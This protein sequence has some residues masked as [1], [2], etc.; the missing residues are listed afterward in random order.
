MRRMLRNV[1]IVLSGIVGIVLIGILLLIPTSVRRGFPQHQGQ[2][3]IEGLDGPA[4]IYRDSFGIPH[5]YATTEHDVIF[6]QGYVH[7]QDRFWQ[8]D[9]QRH[10]SS[11]RL[12]ELIGTNG[13]ETDIFLRTLGWERVAREELASLPEEDV[14]L[15][16]AY[17]DGVNA[18]IKTH[19]GTVMGLEYLFL[20]LLNAAY[21]PEPWTPLHSL[22]W[23]KAMAW[24]LRG[25]MDTEIER[26]ILLNSLADLQLDVNNLYPAYPR[27]MPVI[28]PNFELAG[29]SIQPGAS[30]V[31]PPPSHLNQALLEVSRRFA[32]ADAVLG[33]AADESTGSNSWVVSGELTATGMPLLANDPHL[34]AT[35]PPIWYQNGLHCTPKGPRCAIDAV[36]FSFVGN[37]LIVTGHNDRIS[38]GFTNVGPDVMDLYIEKINPENSLQYEV[39]GEWVDMEL[40]I[41][42][43]QIGGGESLEQDV[44]LTRHGPIISETY[45]LL[46][47]FDDASGVPLP[48]NYAIALRWTALDPG[49]TLS[50]V[51]GFS[52]AQNWDEFRQ[53]ASEFDVPSQNLLYAD[54][55]GNI[56]YQLP[57]RIPVRQPGHD[58]RLP[59]PGWTDENEWVAFIPFEELPFSFNPAEGYIV[60]ANNAVVDQRYPYHLADTWA[61]GY[62]AQRIVD[63]IENAPGPIDIEYMQQMQGDT[64]L[65]GTEVLLPYL[66]DLPLEQPGLIDARDLLDAWDGRMDMDEPAAMLFA[67]L[68]DKLL[69]ATYHDELPEDYWPS[70][71]NRWFIVMQNLLEQPD[72]PWWINQYTSAAEDRDT[73]LLRAFEDALIELT[74][75]FGEDPNAWNWGEQHTIS[76]N[77]QLM[78]SFPAINRLFDRGPF[79]TAGSSDTI[80]NTNWRSY[81]EHYQLQGSNPS[82]RMIV[83]LGNWQNSLAISTTGQSGHPYHANYIDM[84]DLW[85]TIQYHPMN[86]D[87]NAVEA[88]AVAQQ[89]LEP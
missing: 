57:G 53:A 4:D 68:W 56:G 69:V 89:R 14:S 86:F 12:S 25:N 62:R 30:S 38:W 72:S 36:G 88:S 79:A 24:D 85:R 50:A 45:G 44:Y 60:T 40:I 37:P 16:Q 5:I 48:E 54:I 23:A 66:R 28:V 82:Y 10:V 26:A 41:E 74:G 20:P 1:L 58:G 6:V 18:Y 63:L 75:L 31:P 8:M 27:D 43:I 2:F 3:T 21:E 87:F 47:S 35:I 52:R 71:S 15:L 7:S 70:G 9:F 81:N 80:N 17:A 42:S 61:Y 78:S 29:P 13:L 34:S 64:Y 39:N 46:E 59:V 32:Q 11:G 84:A 51:F 65:I 73:I 76:F 33:V 22:T 83:D 19:S 67:A 55:E 77:H 49:S